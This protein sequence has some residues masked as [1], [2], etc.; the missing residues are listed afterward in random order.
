MNYKKAIALKPDYI[1]AMGNLA[2]IYFYEFKNVNRAV[3]VN[4]RIMHI[5]PA[6]DVPY[7]NLANYSL[8][9]GDTA[10][11][12]AYNGKSRCTYPQ[13]YQTYMRLSNYF[14]SKHDFIKADKYLQL[15]EQAKR[16]MLEMK[17]TKQVD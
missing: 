2:N 9:R 15:A 3:A 4:N 13:N 10:M 6:T 11:A 16:R 7:I 5:D 17:N 14:R 12:M 8:R 1:K